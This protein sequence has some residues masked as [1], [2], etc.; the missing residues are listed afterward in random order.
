MNDFG[1][2]ETNI[3]IPKHLAVIM[4]GNGRWA[5]QKG[6]SRSEGHRGGAVASKKLITQSRKLGIEH[7]TLYT[8]SHENWNRSADEVSTLFKLLVEFLNTELKT[9][10]E[11][12]IK[13]SVFG[14]LEKL[15]L[16]A[17]KALQYTIKR[18][19]NCKSMYLNL[20]LN[21]SGRYEIVQ[22]CKKLISEGIKP[23]ELTEKLFSEALYSQGQPDPD[24]IIR[25]S[26]EY[27]IS[28]FLLF[29]SAYSEYYFTPVLWPDFD[30]QELFKALSDYSK[31][32]RR[33]GT[34]T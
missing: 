19:Q 28:N 17:S 27:R 29:Q 34:A 26:G 13:L 12:D 2:T 24:L 4:D 18:T 8:F 5:T 33:F 23:Q 16:A 30:E 31:R 9:L 7:L 32:Q 11:Q 20:A 25:T 22:A 14:E 6:L 21:Y 1:L 3:K 10:E 15:P